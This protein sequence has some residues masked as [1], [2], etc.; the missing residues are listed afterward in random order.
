MYY[1]LHILDSLDKV[2]ATLS[3]E[4]GDDSHAIAS[5][6]ELSPICTMELW[7]DDRRVVR[8]EA[9]PFARV[10]KGDDPDAADADELAELERR[11]HENER[12]LI[13]IRADHERHPT[14]MTARLLTTVED[15]LRDMKE[16][17]LLLIAAALDRSES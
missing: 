2:A 17:R 9:K 14:P 6:G 10:R 15:T 5:I 3:F 11:I 12:N 1:R 13:L 4:C 8:R 16:Y 7:R